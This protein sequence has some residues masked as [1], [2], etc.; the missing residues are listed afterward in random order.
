[1]VGMGGAFLL[2]RIVN[3]VMN[4]FAYQRG[5]KDTFELF[6]TSPIIILGMLL[7]MMFIGL[8]VVFLPA[9]RAEHINP[10]DALRRE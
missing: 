6:A 2:G 8:V 3:I 10:I 7:F 4:A 1:L 5:V 9:R